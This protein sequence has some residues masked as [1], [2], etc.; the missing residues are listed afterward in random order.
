MPWRLFT[1][2][3]ATRQPCAGNTAWGEDA[4]DLTDEDGQPRKALQPLPPPTPE[5]LVSFR[6][7]ML[8]AF[9]DHVARRMEVPTH[10]QGPR[11]YASTLLPETPVYIHPKSGSP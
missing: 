6:Q 7:I 5:Q 10:A 4:E 9:P 3:H 11:P 2:S 1:C 8:A